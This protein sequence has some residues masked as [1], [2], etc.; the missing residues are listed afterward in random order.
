FI[1]SLLDG[2]RTLAEV[3]EA[4]EAAFRPDRLPPEELEALAAELLNRGLAQNESPQAGRLLFRAARKEQRRRRLAALLGFLCIRIPLFDPDRLLGRLLRPLS[5]L[6][7][8]WTLLLALGL[9]GSALLLVTTHWHAF[10]NRLPAQREFFTPRTL[11]F[12]W[13]A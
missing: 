2:T 10:L 9:V 5:L 3:R 4:Y 13:L 11:L 6:G 8:R 12:L 7:S 1:A